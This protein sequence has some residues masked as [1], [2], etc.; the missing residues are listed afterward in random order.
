MNNVDVLENDI[1]QMYPDVLPELL[2]DHTTGRN[3]FW[4]TDDY[5]ELGE[6]YDFNSEITI[7]SI[8]GEHEGII[9][10]RV[11]KSR[12][13]QKGRS[14]KMAEIF[15]PAW[16]C[17]LQINYV[18]EVWF[19]CPNKFNVMSEDKR[20]WKS[21]TEHITFP[22]GKTWED[23]IRSTRLEITCGE[24]PYLVSN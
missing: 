13:N 17:N 1:L 19:D 8:T 16:V 21:T 3:I 14:K 20:T 18:D 22:E 6:G 11:L 5:A 15:T 9:K 23:Y 24:A 4:A 10:P 7:E 2:R 12:E